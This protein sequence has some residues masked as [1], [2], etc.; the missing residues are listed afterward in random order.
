MASGAEAAR[1]KDELRTRELEIELLQQVRDTSVTVD[2]C[3]TLYVRV[4]SFRAH[5]HTHTTHTHTHTL[6]T[7]T[8]EL[9]QRDAELV[10]AGAQTEHIHD[11]MLRLRAIAEVCVD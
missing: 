10:E 8:Q 7:H 11:T 2:V 3:R 1:L 6:H 5:T 9:Q 4:L